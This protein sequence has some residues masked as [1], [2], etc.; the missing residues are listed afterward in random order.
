MDSKNNRVDD[1][2]SAAVEDTKSDILLWAEDVYH[3]RHPDTD[4]F[5]ERVQAVIVAAIMAG[6]TMD[7]GVEEKIITYSDEEPWWKLTGSPRTDRFFRE[8]VEALLSK[9]PVLSVFS[10]KQLSEKTRQ[11]AW[12]VSGVFEAKTLREIR[13][14]LVRSRVEGKG[15][16]DFMDRIAGLVDASS[17]H[18][19]NVFRTNVASATGAGRYV[20]MKQHDSMYYGY[21][22]F[23]PGGRRA[24]PLHAAMNGF[25]ARKDDPVWKVIW[26]PNGYEC[27]CQIRGVRKGQAVKIGLID[28]GGNYLRD[29]IFANR[30]QREIVN[31]AEWGGTTVTGGRHNQ[32]PDEGFRGNALIDIL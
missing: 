18:M 25:I 29:R 16:S 20:Q 10:P 22:Y 5:K 1:L 17:H 30:K 26:T 28:E 7:E 14:H 24:R 15:M 32:F 19:E 2:V 4:S 6:V 3:G 9:D 21:R 27:R 23:N 12:Y 8:A 11:T 31:L 13:K